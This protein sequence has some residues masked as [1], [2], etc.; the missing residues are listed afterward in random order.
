M[1]LTQEAQS[2]LEVQL[3][4]SAANAQYNAAMELERF[5]KQLE[6]ENTRH[7]NQLELQLRTA[8]FDAI[9]LAKETLVENA[10]NKPVDT[11]D[12]TAE[13]INKFAEK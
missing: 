10:R 7:A 13:D 1:A 12:V 11:R 8:K 9:R 6:F 3:A 2:D 5:N 4:V